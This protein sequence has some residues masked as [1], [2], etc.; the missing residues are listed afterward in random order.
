[1]HTEKH[2]KK[3]QRKTNKNT[4]RWPLT[5]D[6]EVQQDSGDCRGTCSHEIPSSY[7]K[8]FMSYRVRKLF[9]PIS[10]WWKI[11]K[12]G[13]VTLTFDLWPW[14]SLA[15]VRLSGNVFKRNFIELSAAVHELS[16][17]QRS[18]KTPTK[19]IRS[20]ATARTVAVTSD[21]RTVSHTGE[22]DAPTED[23]EYEVEYEEWAENDESH[24]VHP[25]PL[26]A[27]RIVYLPTNHAANCRQS[28]TYKIFNIFNHNH[29]YTD[30][31][32]FALNKCKK[33]LKKMK[34]FKKR[35]YENEEKNVR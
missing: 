13:P 2:P 3:H 22:R 31:L 1:M 14:D 27:L 18:R 34:I 26:V 9:C 12:S 16:C 24:E 19:T 6:H 33:T 15:F 28:N 35:F 5:Y 25:R 17:V 21:A 10:Q 30:R 8:R 11:R 23:A 29:F 4:W 32:N 7:V 20:V